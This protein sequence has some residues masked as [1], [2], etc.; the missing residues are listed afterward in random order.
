MLY[1]VIPS[2]ISIF[3]SIALI[4]VFFS[5]KRLASLEN[6]IFSVMMFTNLVGLV[7][8]LMCSFA[9]VNADTLSFISLFILKFYLCYV[10]LF[11]LMFVTYSMVVSNRK[12]GSKKE[13]PS[14]YLK[15]I[16]PYIS[17]CYF[18]CIF[19]VT[20]LPINMFY[21]NNMTY[22]YGPSVEFVY[23]ACGIFLLIIVLFLCLNYKHVRQKKYYPMFI[24]V[25]ISIFISA[26]QIK[27]PYLILA[28]SMHTFVTVLMFH[29]IEN[30]DLKLINELNL[31]K[32]AAER[33]NMAKSEFL[34]NMSHEI[35]TP[36]NAIDGFSQAI[37]EEND[38]DTMKEEAKDI[39]MASQSLLE[40]VNGI[41]D[42]S[43][44]EANKLEIVNSDYNT[45]EL[46]NN[47]IALIRTRVGEK[48][49]VFKTNIDKQI[50]AVL[51]GDSTRLRQII[52]N[53]L[54]NAIKYTKEG[55]VDFSVNTVI[56]ND[57][58]RLI[59]CVEDSGIG[60]KKEDI[61]KLFTKFQRF[62]MVK[63]RTAEGTGLGLAITKTLVELMGGKI[64]VQSEYAKGSKF[65][66][67]IDQRIVAVENVKIK[68][69]AI[70]VEEIVDVTGKKILVVDDNMVNLKV[71]A[72]LLRN[73]NPD[74]TQI[75]SGQECLDK[76]N[77]GEKYDLILM[78]DMMPHMSG[79]ET[80]QKLKLMEDFNIPIVILTANALS[81]MRENYLGMGFDDYLAKPIDRLELNRV[82]KKFLG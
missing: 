27:Y 56:N 62:D 59:I 9:V 16:M 54:T 50:P 31:A 44:I 25:V 7:L 82:I 71:A 24:F 34:S 66:V 43:K 17:V 30:P 10:L 15:R 12:I 74:I 68:E 33:A 14:K 48:P 60:I 1:S 79:V 32:E 22:T 49:V 20:I 73:Y 81:G 23:A 58:C 64:I 11:A 76:I 41:L 3:Y 39:M 21:E 51:F 37:L 28:T 70:N 26:L 19:F 38:I 53:L 63:N 57:V 47:V 13:N 36:L 72:R 42:I 29:T 55:F 18:V 52:L 78:D 8:E 5:K 45:E 75:S 65:T 6:K 77:N 46:L 69:E 80:F 67:A 61:S 35:R 4:I 40:L 2:A